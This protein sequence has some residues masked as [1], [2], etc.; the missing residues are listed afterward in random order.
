MQLEPVRFCY[1]KDNPLALDSTVHH[2]GLVAQ[3]VQQVMPE[4]VKEVSG[5]KMGSDPDVAA[6]PDY[7]MIDYDPIYLAGN[8]AIRE[9]GVLNQDLAEENALLK[10][11]LDALEKVVQGLVNNQ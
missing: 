6:I 11:R 4:A 1:S 9:L 3:D 7:L 8:N 2:C 10:A 5:Q